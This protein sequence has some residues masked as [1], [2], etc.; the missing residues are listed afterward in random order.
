MNYFY[1]D[2]G[3]Q[4]GGGQ[5]LEQTNVELPIFWN[6]EISNY[7]ITSRVIRVG[8]EIPNDQNNVE[9]PIF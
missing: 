5:H 1:Q 4:S 7:K 6:F 3:I 9:R 8:V 2:H